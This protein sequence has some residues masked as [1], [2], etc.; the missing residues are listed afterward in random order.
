MELE[1]LEA[2]LLVHKFFRRISTL[3]TAGENN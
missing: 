3:F 1:M 2:A